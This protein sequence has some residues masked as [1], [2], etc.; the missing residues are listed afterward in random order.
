MTS[1]DLESLADTIQRIAQ[2]TAPLGRFMDGI[3]NDMEAIFKERNHW[4]EEQKNKRNA[5]ETAQKQRDDYLK[6]LHERLASLEEQVQEKINAIQRKKSNLRKNSE[7][8]KKHLHAVAK[9]Y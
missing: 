9:A 3:Q 4:I 2:S 5:L 7:T 8:I 1:Q 6:P